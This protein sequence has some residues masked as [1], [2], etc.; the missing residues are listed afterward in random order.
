MM[1]PIEGADY[2]VQVI[3]FPTACPAFVMLN[4]DGTY[5]LFLNAKLDREQQL[6]GYEHELWHMIRDDLYGDKD[7]WKIETNMKAG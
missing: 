1:L 7:A 5:T 3:P 6:D 4:A 2:F